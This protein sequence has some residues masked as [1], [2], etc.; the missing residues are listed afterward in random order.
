[1]RF[2]ELGTAIFCHVNDKSLVTSKKVGKRWRSFINGQKTVWIRIIEKHIGKCSTFSEDWK[3][4]VF[5]T[6]NQIVKDLAIAVDKY[7]KKYSKEK[8]SPLFISAQQGNLQLSQY[9]IGKGVD[10]NW[11]IS[12]PCTSAF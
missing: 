9:L 4:A 1:M 6:P 8:V 12:G 11:L 2:P 7:H 3:K 10:K 5:K